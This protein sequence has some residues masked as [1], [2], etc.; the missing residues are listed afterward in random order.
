MQGPRA[1]AWA[2]HCG[3]GAN[4]A[5]RIRCRDC[6]RQAPRSILDKATAAARAAA[7]VEPPRTG[8][9][10]P[11][12]SPA[13]RRGQATGSAAGGKAKRSFAEVVKS[14]GLLEGGG[15]EAMPATMDDYPDP[16]ADDEPG[17]GAKHRYWKA[18]RQAAQQAGMDDDVAE[19][20]L[21]LA[22]LAA[23]VRANRPWEARLQAASRRHAKLQ[24]TSAQATKD[25]EAAEAVLLAMQAAEAA[26]AA[27]E[28]EAARE[29]A[30]VKAEV[31][32][33]PTQQQPPEVPEQSMEALIGK[34]VA[35][36]TQA[37]LD[38]HALARMVAEVPGQDTQGGPAMPPSIPAA[39]GTPLAAAFQAGARR[40]AAPA[41]RR[42]AGHERSRSPARD[43]HAGGGGAGVDG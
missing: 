7:S 33:A 29:L 17:P 35:L 14:M 31:A 26:A 5:C 24:A 19:C 1:P 20:D 21:A 16:D 36:A 18:R 25:R 12:S 4:W 23:Q 6:G 34:L 10:A 42:G 15:D 3:F 43:S 22:A 38:V 2:C 40:S 9:A 13:P 27:A 39:Q 37:G 30:S 11:Q 28:A 32:V 8:S 41:D